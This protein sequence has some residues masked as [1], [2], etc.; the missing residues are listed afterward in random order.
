MKLLFAPDSFKGSLSSG[1]VIQLLTVAAKKVWKDCSIVPVPMADGGEGTMEVLVKMKEGHFAFHTVTGPSGR[2]VKARY[3]II[4][5]ETAM[6]E[7]AEASGLPLIPVEE[8]NPCETSSY[9]TGE[10][11][12]H[13]LKQGYSHIIM[14]IGGS[15]T[16]DGGIGAAAALGIQFLDEKNQPLKPVGKNLSKIYHIDESYV[17]PEFTKAEFTIICDV[18][19]PLT[20]SCGS[21]YVYGAQKGGTPS[22]LDELEKGM[23]HYAEIVKKQYGLDFSQ[24][25]GAGAAG[26]ISVPFLTFSNSRLEAGIQ[27]VLDTIQFDTLLEGVDLVVTG[28]GQVDRQSTYGK[29]LAGIGLACKQKNIPAVAIVGSMGEGAEEIYSYGIQSIMPIL[30]RPMELDTAIANSDTLF[31]DAAE[32]MFRFIQTGMYMKR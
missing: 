7:M 17:L 2:P 10:L 15:A 14:A 23:I 28:E 9:G 24:M 4:N 13:I 25:E 22:Q 30:N 20:G 5:Q 26:G 32:R 12:A 21:T 1:Q 19:N 18:K 3:G 8:R 27:V 31:L 6:V 29:V 11:I 16:N